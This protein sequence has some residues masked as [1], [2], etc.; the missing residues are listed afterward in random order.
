MRLRKNRTNEAVKKSDLNMNQ[1]R[2]GGRY[3]YR[4]K[5]EHEKCR[6]IVLSNKAFTKIVSE[7]FSYGDA[8]TG[9][10][11]IG[12]ICNG[13]W[14]VTDVIDAGLKP[15]TTHTSTYFVY[16]EKY[17]NHRIEKE[18]IIYKY[19]PTCLGFF[20]RHPGSFDTFSVPDERTMKEH[21]DMSR[22]GLISMLVNIDPKLRM[23]FYYASK[24]DELYIVE[25][26][27][28]DELIPAKYLEIASYEEIAERFHTRVKLIDNET[29]RESEKDISSDPPILLTDPKLL[30]RISR[31]EKNQHVR[32]EKVMVPEKLAEDD[33]YE[34]PLYGFMPDTGAYT[35]LSWGEEM[36]K[37]SGSK[38]VGYKLKSKAG[39][40]NSLKNASENMI[41]LLDNKAGLYDIHTKNIQD[42]EI[43]KYSMIQSLT[44]RNSGLLESEYMRSATVILSGCGSV[45]SLA[46]CQ[47]ARSGVGNMVL[48]D[49]DH[50]EIHNICRH[51]LNLADIGRKKVDA[52]ADK[53]KLINPDINIMT[54]D[55]TFQEVPLAEYINMIKDKDKTIF[56]GACD[57]RVGNAKVCKM[58][59]DIGVAFAA[60]GFLP[61]AWGAEVFT[62]LPGEME[63]ETVFEKQIR[64]AIITEHSNHHYLD[65]EDQGKITF[66]PGLDVDIEYGTSFFDKIVLDILNRNNP[67]YHMRIYDKLTQYTLLAGTQDIPDEFYKKHIEP[68]TPVSVELDPSYYNLKKSS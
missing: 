12:L 6:K 50:L 17:V 26:Q 62:M 22:H 58:A 41:I 3:L 13:V 55:R 43:E 5:K 48:M 36:P 45:G 30:A 21:C 64:E 28:G 63:Y 2:S 11:F 29:D 9:G 54:F 66:E 60:V 10:V 44:S 33:S 39:L 47:L 68:L 18:G 49:A 23:T 51:Q 32:S 1:V 38:L 34:G 8:E 19:Q 37:V 40:R 65:E 16:D 4:G 31:M 20:H 42:I 59:A 52:V 57:N 67:K 46:A 24:Q 15:D 53:L 56:I 7:T 61:R 35:I 25:Y 14:Y 27:A